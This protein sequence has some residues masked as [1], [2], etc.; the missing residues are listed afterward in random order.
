MVG[1]HT[2][3]RRVTNSLRQHELDEVLACIPLKGQRDTWAT[4]AGE[5]FTEAQLADLRRKIGIS[6]ERM[7]QR[8][9]GAPWLAGATYSLADVNC[10]RWWRGCRVSFPIS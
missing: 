1:W 4:I 2:M 8:L 10:S 3:V 5:S 7:E 6:I 9:G